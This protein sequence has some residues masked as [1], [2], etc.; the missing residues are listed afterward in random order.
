MTFPSTIG[1]KQENLAQ[2]WYIARLTAS[3]LKTESQNI[4]NATASDTRAD[5]IISYA[6]RLADIRDRL[7]A[8]SGVSG[9]AAYAQAQIDDDQIDIVTEFQNMIDAIDTTVTWIVANFPKDGSDYLLEKKFNANGRTTA[10]L[11]TVAQLAT[12]R[13][14]VSSI[15]A[16]ID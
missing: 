5:I 11:L 6:T 14:L 12:L 15:I 3:D 8:S 1:T 2:A 10:R 7:A 9:I 16:T 13:T 4:Y